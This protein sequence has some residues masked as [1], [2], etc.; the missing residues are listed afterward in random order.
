MLITVAE[1]LARIPAN[2]DVIWIIKKT[3]KVIPTSKAANLPLS[4]TSSLN[5]IFRIPFTVRFP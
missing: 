2:M 3:A 1:D 4:F 5:A